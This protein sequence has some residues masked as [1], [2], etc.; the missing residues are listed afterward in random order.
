MAGGESRQF[1]VGT[2]AGN[3]VLEVLRAVEEVSGRKVPYKIV[4]R[5]DGDSPSLV[6]NSKKLQKALGWKPVRSDL[7]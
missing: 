2:G 3:T 1:N 5:R 6:A 7:N 4:P